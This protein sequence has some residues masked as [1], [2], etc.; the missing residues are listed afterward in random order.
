MIW[1]GT[2]VPRA[3][4]GVP[5]KDNGVCAVDETGVVFAIS[6]ERLSSL[7]HD[8]GHARA[9]A[10][11]L[12]EVPEAQSARTIG[13]TSCTDPSW[14]QKTL[15][16]TLAGLRPVVVPSHHHSH[17]LSGFL[18]SPFDE[19]L[20]LV[21]DAGGNT[22]GAQR[23]DWWRTPREQ[24]TLWSGNGDTIT[25]LERRH[26]EP[27][28]A[29]FGEWYRAFTYFLGW[30]RS[31]LAGNTM[32]LSGFGDPAAIH[33]ESLFDMDPALLPPL[34]PMQPESMVQALLATLGH[35]DIE[36]RARG[37]AM[38]DGHKNAAAY[39]QRSL[40]HT[41]RRWVNEWSQRYGIRRLCLSGGVSQN[42]RANAELAAMLGPSNVYVSP[43]AGDVGQSIGNALYARSMDRP[44]I[45][46]PRLDN[47]FLG[48]QYREEDYRAALDARSLTAPRC[49]RDELAERCADALARG[50]IVATCQGRS[51]FGPRALGHRSVL[52]DPCHPGIAERIKRA[53]K[54]RD[55]FMPLAPVVDRDVAD[56]WDT[57]ALS[58]TMVLAPTAP[59][60]LHAELGD[61]LHIDKTARVQVATPDA[62]LFAP[63]LRAFRQRTNRG[64]LINTS[65]NRRGH[66][67]V[68]TPD[69][70]LTAYAEL[71]IDVLILGPY[72]IAKEETP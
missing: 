37:A 51:E 62:G 41:L 34:T 16:S 14:S 2:H 8:H 23:D 18:L 42:C 64:V 19:S 9:F 17:A 40:E 25:L 10:R 33:S 48:P 43:F 13:V 59:R 57:D 30:H 21:M 38:T 24:T 56:A 58:R 71:D 50:Q 3:A 29:G 39:L 66:P 52:G 5:L 55:E 61:C 53:V 49:E 68:E 60:S 7:K 27:G 15:D 47:T 35:R 44:D 70:A 45:P 12:E 28:V 67:I 32:A 4:S 1:L 63:V 65:F 54:Q 46:R 6:E 69:D 36:P 72:W 11:C 20:I 22:L 26:L 31:T